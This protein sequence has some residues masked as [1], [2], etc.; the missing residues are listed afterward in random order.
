MPILSQINPDNYEITQEVMREYRTAHDLRSVALLLSHY[1]LQG[2]LRAFQSITRAADN[3]YYHSQR[4]AYVTLLNCY[5]G[6]V[7]DGSLE[8]NEI[9]S[10]L[11]AALFHDVN[12]SLGMHPDG[13]N[14]ELACSTLAL[15]NDSVTL[16]MRLP[17]NALAQA[18]EIICATQWPITEPPETNAQRII[19]DADLM[20]AY[21]PNSQRRPLFHGLFCE[22]NARNLSVSMASFRA[23]QMDFA[24]GVTWNTVWAQKKAQALNWMQSS[25]DA[26]DDLHAFLEAPQPQA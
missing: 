9:R 18:L 14:I 20:M 16:S 6:A 5:E 11:A 21:L 7:H 12:H 26:C 19:R 15:V 3:K 2:H 8:D 1:S 24:A 25:I 10:L 13:V 22:L 23:S 4:H 17:P